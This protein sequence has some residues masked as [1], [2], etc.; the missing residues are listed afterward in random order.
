MDVLEALDNTI[1]S[2]KG[3]LFI[4]LKT[5]ICIVV[6]KQLNSFK[7]TEIAEIANRNKGKQSIL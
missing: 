7:F 1:V 3:K 4:Y 5:F 6:K 2:A